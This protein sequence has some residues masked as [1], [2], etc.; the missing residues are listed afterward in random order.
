VKFILLH[1]DS[2]Q[3]ANARRAAREGQARVL[4]VDGTERAPVRGLGPRDQVLVGTSVP[5]F[6]VNDLL[7]RCQG[8]ELADVR[9]LADAVLPPVAR[10]G[11]RWR[12]WLR[13]VH[14]LPG[15]PDVHTRVAPAPLVRSANIEEI[16]RTWGPPP[17]QFAEH[18]NDAPPRVQLQ[19]TTSC[20]I[21]CPYCPRPDLPVGDRRM[22]D[23]LF[24]RIV[25]QCGASGVESL[26]LYLHAEPLEDPRLEAL[27]ERAAA[28]CPGALLS[29]VT[30]EKSIDRS[31]AERLARSSLDVVFVS[32]NVTGDAGTDAIRTRLRRV[33]GIAQVLRGGGKELVVVTLANLL[34]RPG[35]FRRAC[36]DLDLPLQPFRAT[37]RAG[38]VDIERWRQPR[39]IRPPTVC[40]RP[41]TTAHVC[42]DGTVIACCED[43][44]HERVVGHAE[45]ESL[46]AIW[47]GAP[48]RQLRR[49]LLARSPGAP[50]DR[51]ELSGAVD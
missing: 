32:V 20:R 15:S 37:S 40:D 8:A 42:Y 44:R 7:L 12:P 33:S 25:E 21:G 31:R 27:S 17:V 35:P 10:I 24:D 43:W 9:L 23:A 5:T 4:T 38:S 50:C 16:L 39:A 28:A 18:P 49:E 46:A 6:F 41:F 26:E 36:V 48:L 30:H 34:H 51:C 3:L 2:P 29:I 22:D 14:R 11:L 13:A 19:T 47:S 45:A 1:L